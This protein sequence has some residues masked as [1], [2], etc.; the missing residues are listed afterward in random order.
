MLQ[1]IRFKRQAFMMH[2]CAR[3]G[4]TIFV[5]RRNHRCIS[6]SL[7]G[8]LSSSIWRRSESGQ[9]FSTKTS[10]SITTDPRQS[11]TRSNV[12]NLRNQQRDE[13][14]NSNRR[15]QVDSSKAVVEEFEQELAHFRQRIVHLPA[16]PEF[17]SSAELRTKPDDGYKLL[18]EDA[19]AFVDRLQ[20]EIDQRQLDRRFVREITFLLE[21]SLMLFRTSFEDCER[22]M[23]LAR[24]LKLNL[25]NV[26]PA[27]EA[28]CMEGKWNEASLFFSRQID[29]DMAGFMPMEI[30]LKEP[31]GLY[32]I[33]RDAQERK[34]PIAENV[35]DAVMSMAMVNPTDQDKC[36]W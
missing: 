3:P 11:N 8:S 20:H 23:L 30:N 21:Q 33:A 34:V 19:R 15:R 5:R 28:A 13:G 31:I 7:A 2:I 27:L 1:I 18:V 10:N 24:R 36:A 12:L 22:I 9:H 14:I 35:M 29:P 16:L 26:M 25:S 6:S 32:A 4:V 17:W